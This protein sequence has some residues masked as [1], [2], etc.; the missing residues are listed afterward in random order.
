LKVTILHIIESLVI[1]GAE[2]L[3]T[4]SL[5]SISDDY[6]HV[7]VYL[8]PPETLL[9]EV[10]ADKIYCLNYNGKYSLLS[11]AYKL[12]K[13][14]KAEQAKLIHAHH[15]WPTIVARLAKPANV[16][17]ITTI[18]GLLSKDAFEPN[19]L[20][21]YLERLTYSKKHHLVF[22]SETVAQDYR[23]YIET[24]PRCSVFYNFA[25]DEFFLPENN[26]L[27]KGS[28][29]GF[30][31]VAIATLKA[32]KNH[33]L[34]LEASKLLKG[35]EIY[36]DIIGDGPLKDE[37]Q[38]TIE[39]NR[40]EKVNLK[41][42]HQKVYE[43]LQQYD[44][45]ILAS[46]HEGFGIAMVEA[47]AVGLPCILSDIEAHREVTANNALFFDLN[48]PEDCAKKILE[49]KTN[50]ELRTKLALSGKVR[51]QKF[52]KEA[53]LQQIVALYKQYLT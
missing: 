35:E 49:L 21:L 46:A 53:Y 41:G 48:S 40:L 20:S 39:D 45:F 19:H 12:R 38:K 34:L 22:V 27:V 2:V 30:R 3:L 7:V 36:L 15:Y 16:Q 31:L 32:A 10:K 52:K 42:E 29:E 5:K 11:C 24:G 1:G 47:M 8:R 9:P 18:H 14:I 44:G 26:S 28:S 37:L 51:A 23:K 25:K 50:T 13:I 17:L 33:T 6:R 43:L 4:E